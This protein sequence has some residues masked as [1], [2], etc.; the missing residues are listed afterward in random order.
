[1]R[2]VLDSPAIPRLP[3]SILLSPVVRL[4][5]A[6]A[7]CNVVVAGGVAKERTEAVGRVVVAVGVAIERIQVTVGRVGVLPSVLLPSAPSPLAVLLAPVVL[8]YER[9]NTVGR[10][11][12]AGG[13]AKERTSA[14]GRVA[15]AG[16][17]AIERLKPLPCCPAVG[18]A[19][20]RFE[21]RWPC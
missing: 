3:I 13:V 9:I 12:D 17:V 8:L 14:V 6:E 16:G 11:A 21:R 20:E 15:A 2:I 5:P 1:M 18:V 7:Q 4:K 10:V 19:I